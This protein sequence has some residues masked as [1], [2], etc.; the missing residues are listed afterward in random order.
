MLLTLYKTINF[1][2][3]ML[4]YAKV[5]DCKRMQKNEYMINQKTW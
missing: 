2:S 4:F 3:N 1:C 5:M